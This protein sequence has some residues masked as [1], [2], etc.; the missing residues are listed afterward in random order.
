MTLW[1]VSQFVLMHFS[2]E[3]ATGTDKSGVTGP[4]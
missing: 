1:S 3:V 4:S 2:S